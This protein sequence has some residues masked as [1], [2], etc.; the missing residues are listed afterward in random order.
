MKV[1]GV[2]VVTL[3][4]DDILGWKSTIPIPKGRMAPKC[5]EQGVKITKCAYDGCKILKIKCSGLSPCDECI[6][7]RISCTL[8]H[9]G[10]WGPRRLR[11][12][13]LLRR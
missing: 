7:G 3:L 11:T 8:K 9:P 1:E 13:T 4:G 10:T 5:R 6:A 12:R 2:V